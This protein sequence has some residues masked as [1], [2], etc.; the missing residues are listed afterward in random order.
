MC[1]IG[2]IINV[3]AKDVWDFITDTT[4][5]PEWGLSV[6]AVDCNDRYIK[7]GSRGKVKLPFGIWVPFLITDYEDKMYWSWSV[8]GIHATGHRTLP[9]DER[10]CSL[11]FEVPAIAAPYLLIC[12]IAIKRIAAILEHA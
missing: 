11:I 4:R 2:S 6:T 3:P 7:K 9:I 8:W 1:E 12:W 10:R 5:W